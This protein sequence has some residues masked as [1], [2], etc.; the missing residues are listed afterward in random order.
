MINIHHQSNDIES[1]IL[2]FYGI[3]TQDELKL[4]VGLPKL[5]K[6]MLKE[7]TDIFPSKWN[8]PFERF[9]NT[10]PFTLDLF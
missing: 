9:P 6:F 4:V 7:E 2:S 5:S 3:I 8:S 1:F 10:F